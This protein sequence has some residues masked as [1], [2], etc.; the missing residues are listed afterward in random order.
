[1]TRATKGLLLS[2]L[3]IMALAAC[4]GDDSSGSSE[5]DLDAAAGS[6][7]EC[8]YRVEEAITTDFLAER[9]IEV[10]QG[11][12][13]LAFVGIRDAIKSTCRFVEPKA[14]VGGT[15]DDVVSFLGG[16]IDPQDGSSTGDDVNVSEP[17]PAVP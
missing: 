15:A 9:G 13:A 2:S 12:E 11:M 10:E 1:M 4:G 6:P 3:A 16:Q 5:V 7:K 8:A 14:T 17:A